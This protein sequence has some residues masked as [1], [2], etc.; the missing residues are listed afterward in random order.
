MIL[1][2]ANVATQAPQSLKLARKCVAEHVSNRRVPNFDSSSIELGAKAS[3]SVALH[4]GGTS[5]V[6][7]SFL[8][9]LTQRESIAPSRVPG[10]SWK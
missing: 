5:I 9:T 8:R 2:F 7:S 10:E 6:D 3:R 4:L 1:S